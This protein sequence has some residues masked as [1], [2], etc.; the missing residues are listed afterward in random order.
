[1]TQLKKRTFGGAAPRQG[2]LV[3]WSY[4]KLSMYE[5]CPRQARYRYIEKLPEPPSPHLE[6]GERTH[7][8]ME[9]WVKA[10]APAKAAPTEA[11]VFRDHVSGYMPPDPSKLVVEALWGHD[12][13]WKPTAS[14]RETW[15][16]IKL[17]LAFAASGTVI[18]WK[19]GK[20]HDSHEDQGNL[21][22]VAFLHRYP[23]HKEVNVEFAYLDLGELASMT[24]SRRNLRALQGDFEKRVAAMGTDTT[25]KP[26]PSKLCGWCSYSK[27]KG[28]PCDAG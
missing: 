21:Y 22:G 27:T 19:T 14:Y 23:Q 16:W 18:D 24:V 15:L 2:T 7:K 9:A 17:D 13:S 4:S 25:F 26:R 6:R 20:A 5:K 28:G 8:S 3:P 12:K 11:K 10:G 1:M